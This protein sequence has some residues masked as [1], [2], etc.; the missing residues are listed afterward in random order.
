[1]K[2]KI[3]LAALVLFFGRA[4]SQY[5]YFKWQKTL[6]YVAA[7]NAK[8]PGSGLAIDQS[9]RTFYVTPVGAN[10]RVYW[11]YGDLLGSAANAAS[12]SNMKHM[13]TPSGD[14]LFYITAN[15]RIGLTQYLYSN[16]YWTYNSSYAVT[17]PIQPGPSIAPQSLNMVFYIRASDGKVCNYWSNPSASGFGPVINSA[18][19]AA[20]YSNLVL[21][22]DRVFYI[23]STGQIGCLQFTWANGWQSVTYPNAPGANSIKPGSKIQVRGDLTSFAVFFITPNNDIYQYTKNPTYSGSDFIAN[24]AP[25]PMSGT[26]IVTYSYD[27]VRYVD[28]N[29]NVQALYNTD[30]GWSHYTLNSTCGITDPSLIGGANNSV[31]Y[32]TNTT[33]GIYK[34]ANQSESSG[35]VYKKGTKLMLG[36]GRFNTIGMN[37]IANIYSSDGGATF[38]PGPD[39]HYANVGTNPPS[40]QAANLTMFDQHLAEIASLGFTSIRFND[41][42]ILTDPNDYTNPDLFIS[43]WDPTF[44]WAPQPMKLLDQ[45]TINSLFAMY[46]YV[47]N[48]CAFYNLKVKF[49]IGLEHGHRNTNA[50]GTYKAYLQQFANYFQNNNTIYSYAILQEADINPNVHPTNP[51]AFR[52]KGDICYYVD[53]LYQAIRSNDQNHLVNL[54]VIGSDCVRSFDPAILNVDFMSFH[55]YPVL[56]D[57]THQRLKSELQW[58]S[59]VMKKI[60]KPWII[61]ETG[62]AGSNTGLQATGSYADQ[63]AYA[64]FILDAGF[65]AGASGVCWWHYKDVYWPGSSCCPDPYLTTYFPGTPMWD[66]TSNYYALKAHDGSL[67][68]AAYVFQDYTPQNGCNL[69]YPPDDYYGSLDGADFNYFGTVTNQDGDA[70]E[71]AQV[72][73]FDWET[74]D[75]K[76]KSTFSHPNGAFALQANQVVNAVYV[77]APGYNTTIVWSPFNMSNVVLTPVN[78]GQGNPRMA[79]S[80]EEKPEGVSSIS[81]YPNPNNGI[82]TLKGNELLNGVVN[83][84]VTDVMGRSLMKKNFEKLDGEIV[85]LSGFNNGIYFIRITCGDFTEVKKVIKK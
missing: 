15:N 60:D 66:N 13:N 4:H 71:D 69:A 51:S 3:L 79:T 58:V 39:G 67:K 56:S 74:E 84:N 6:S 53:D 9:D 16:G 38:F 70:L 77:T 22:N 8:V 42:H 73:A 1:M 47:L 12:T 33:N 31:F 63:A 78:C 80:V 57:N 7:V 5:D 85:D 35:F 40:S 50:L 29:G 65:S 23:T 10:H 44:P 49:F 21:N 43:Y 54:S 82:F 76:T 48:R 59:K 25:K 11:Q 68:P 81:L 14:H 36:N 28:V 52:G 27:E 37:Y 75:K 61:G 64:Q 72:L 46:D 18:P 26:D 24:G 2:K 20:P 62:M 32:Y 30:C 55:L 41:F 45:Q 19:S 34:L 83:M 17:E